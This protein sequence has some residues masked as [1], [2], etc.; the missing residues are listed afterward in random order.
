MT[1]KLY[2]QD[3][4]LTKFTAR[5]QSQ[6]STSE[7]QI[8]VLDQTAF[9]PTG[10]GQPCDFG[11]INSA[12]VDD[13]TIA[14]DGLIQHHLAT[15]IPLRNGE[16]VAGAIDWTR[17]QELLQQHTGQHILS[18]AFFQLF[19]AET[20]GFRINTHTSEID[21]TLDLSSDTLSQQ[22]Q[23]A[24]DLA[25]EI[26]FANR[27]IRAHL[28]TP[29]EAARLPLRKET[30]VD[31]C[32]RVIEIADFDWS[33]CGGTHAQQTG[34]VG[35]IVIKHWE[36]AKQMIRVEF[37]CGLRALRDYRAVNVAADAIARQFSV[38]REAAPESVTRL[39]EENKGLKRRLRLLAETAVKFEA[40]ELRKSVDDS[41]SP[42]VI[43]A[44]FDDRSLDELKLLAHQLVKFDSVIA[45]LAA[46]E[47]GAVRLVF[48]RSANVSMVMG[49]LMRE[50]CQALG[51]KGGGTP[52]F[53]Q[54]GG[55][56]VSQL[57]LVLNSLREKIHA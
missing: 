26:V 7:R 20:R 32:V 8:V 13:V 14:T 12:R 9:Y 27:E 44:V 30:F 16:E 47:K 40:D 29:E 42:Q 52:D 21:L 53:A 10:G 41:S 28:V 24:E 38:A 33:A 15:P 18:Q 46:R 39:I 56:D 17:R 4:H 25:N 11:I 51:G 23:Q 48:A 5:V 31:D 49:E 35:L 43:I 37:L 2:W 22:M 3:S 1:I 57:E 45:L 55:T 50:A 54:G 34:E 19:G 6:I 36:R